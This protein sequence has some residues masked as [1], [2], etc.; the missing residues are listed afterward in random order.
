MQFL[1]RDERRN[2]KFEKMLNKF[3]KPITQSN[4]QSILMSDDMLTSEK[5]M[6]FGRYAENSGRK[7][8]KSVKT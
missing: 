3:E 6:R 4:L 2:L 7:E 8:E 1:E 5:T